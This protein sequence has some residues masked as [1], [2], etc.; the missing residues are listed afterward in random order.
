MHR[1]RCRTRTT[2]ARDVQRLFEGQ[3]KRNVAPYADYIVGLHNG[4]DGI[5][6][7]ITLFSEG[8]LE[9]QENEDGSCFIQVPWGEQLVAIDGETQLAARHEAANMAPE[10]KSE[11]VP[12]YICH[13]RDK[14]WARRPSTTST[15]LASNRT[16]PSASVW[17]LAIHSRRCAGRL[18]GRSRSSRAG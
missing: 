2:C 16:L 3:K 5:T 15:R 14:H 18:S 11:F 10:S 1:R 17:M 8:S 12:V 7:P 13:G 4:E 9:L 6:P